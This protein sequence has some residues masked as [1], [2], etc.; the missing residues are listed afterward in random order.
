M[1]NSFPIQFGM[2]MIPFVMSMQPGITIA[3]E[4]GLSERFSMVM[5]PPAASIEIDERELHSI[6]DF[7]HKAERAIQTENIDA[8]MALYSYSYTNL[9]N[10]DKHFAAEIWSKIFARF[11][12]ISS[13]H[14]MKLITY[15]KAAGRAVTECSGLLFGTPEGENGLIPI[16]RWDDQKHMLVKEGQW[17]LL[18]NAGESALRYGAKDVKLHPLF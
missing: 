13:R 7:F 4:M 14:S 6:A 5:R 11:D 8:L 12:N 1:T 17:K 10:G 9:R 15:D 2:L 16:D 3:E 18:G